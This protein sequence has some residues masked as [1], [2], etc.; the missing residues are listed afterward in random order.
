MCDLLA[1]QAY[2]QYSNTVTPLLFDKLLKGKIFKIRYLTE[3]FSSSQ[4]TNTLSFISCLYTKSIYR[5]KTMSQNPSPSY[6]VTKQYG[7]AKKWTTARHWLSVTVNQWQMDRLEIKCQLS[8]LK[9]PAYIVNWL[10]HGYYKNDPSS[11]KFSL[12]S[13]KRTEKFLLPFNSGPTH[14]IGR[15]SISLQQNIVHVLRGD[16]W[17]PFLQHA[18]GHNRSAEVQSPAPLC[19]DQLW[20]PRQDL[21]ISHHIVQ[22]Q[23]SNRQR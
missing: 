19:T 13:L 14:V 3:Q 16:I 21:A 5:N 4:N 6:N 22:V 1:E 2:R 7:A 20:Q 17:L 9:L 18:S 23:G 10:D 15:F 11:L 8:L 12:L